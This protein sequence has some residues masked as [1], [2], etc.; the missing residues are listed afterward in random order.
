[1]VSMNKIVDVSISLNNSV[2]I[3]KKLPSETKISFLKQLIEESIN[4]SQNS[5]ELYYNNRNYIKFDIFSLKEAFIGVKTLNLEIIIIIP[6][7]TNNNNPSKN[8]N[9]NS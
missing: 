5:Y 1:M 2:A 6:Q 4:L 3:Q 9:L 8:K 7:D